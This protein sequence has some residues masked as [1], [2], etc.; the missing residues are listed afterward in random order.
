MHCP[1]HGAYEISLHFCFG[2]HCEL[3]LVDIIV[4]LIGVGML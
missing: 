4:I 3:F 1:V 2:A